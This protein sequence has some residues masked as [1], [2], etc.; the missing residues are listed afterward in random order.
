M[1]ETKKALDDYMLGR[2]LD[3][4]RLV[5]P[6]DVERGGLPEASKKYME[7]LEDLL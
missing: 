5:E 3:Y 6:S 4:E 1:E 7:M 2:N